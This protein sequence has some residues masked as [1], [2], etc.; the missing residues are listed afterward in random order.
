MA[1]FAD[2]LFYWSICSSE[3]SSWLVE[4][5]KDGTKT[6]LNFKSFI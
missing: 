6:S 5:L 3:K 1:R 2:K 4:F